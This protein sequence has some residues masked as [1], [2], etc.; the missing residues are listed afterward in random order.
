M[1]TET[2]STVPYKII[3]LKTAFFKKCEILLLKTSAYATFFKY[4]GLNIAFIFTF[5]LKSIE[6]LFFSF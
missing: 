3:N 1:A 2:S 5:D 4:S 6:C